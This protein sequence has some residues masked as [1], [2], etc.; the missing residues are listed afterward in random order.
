MIVELF[1]KGSGY[2]ELEFYSYKRGIV[3]AEFGL[4]CVEKKI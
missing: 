2:L 3:H 1:H 4:S